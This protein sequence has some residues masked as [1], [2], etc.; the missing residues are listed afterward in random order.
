[1]TQLNH[2][3]GT[4]E[5]HRD[6]GRAEGTRGEAQRTHTHTH[7]HLEQGHTGQSVRVDLIR[8]H[9]RKQ[10]VC[11]RGISLICAIVQQRIVHHRI[12]SDTGLAHPL[13][14]VQ[15]PLRLPCHTTQL[16]LLQKSGTD[17]PS[18]SFHPVDKTATLPPLGA[19]SWNT[20]KDK[21]SPSQSM[22]PHNTVKQ[23]PMMASMT[24][25]V[26]SRIFLHKNCNR[27]VGEGSANHND[28]IEPRF[29]SWPMRDPYR[30]TSGLVGEFSMR[31]SRECEEGESWVLLRLAH[32]V[33]GVRKRTSM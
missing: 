1:M 22:K 12:W 26:S 17:S 16:R 7:T 24:V 30:N 2:L 28:N 32:M 6:L 10:R 20:G 8:T 33:Q 5:C 25:I 11:Q 27:M 31:V 4:K 19:P 21:N 15:R 14:E 18:T 3:Q 9:S 29:S 23:D 13:Q